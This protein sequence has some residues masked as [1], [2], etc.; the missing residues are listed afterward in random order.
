MPK[1]QINKR[2]FTSLLLL[3]ADEDVKA[4]KFANKN[5]H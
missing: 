1:F 2:L 4:S 3:F 5:A